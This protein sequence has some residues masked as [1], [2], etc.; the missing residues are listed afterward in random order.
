MQLSAEPRS[1]LPQPETVYNRSVRC[2][3]GG[4]RVERLLRVDVRE[5]ATASRSSEHVRRFGICDICGWVR[6]QHRY[7]S[8]FAAEDNY[9]ARSSD[10]YRAALWPAGN[11]ALDVEILAQNVAKLLRASEKRKEARKLVVSTLN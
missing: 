5:S 7:I 4:R 9:V 3:S 6:G 8:G 2:R 10:A 11:Y 1:H